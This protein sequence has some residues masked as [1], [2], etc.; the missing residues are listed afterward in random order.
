MLGP[1]IEVLIYSEWY[2]QPFECT[3]RY[4]PGGLHPVSLHDTLHNRHRILYKLGHTTFA[5]V[6]LAEN[7]CFREN[8]APRYVAV[9]IFSADAEKGA[10]NAAVIRWLRGGR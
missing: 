10:I 4:K 1:T 2:T 9:K 6:W 8:N 3:A 7:L 5:T